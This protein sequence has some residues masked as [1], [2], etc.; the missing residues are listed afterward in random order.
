MEHLV[1]YVCTQMQFQSVEC[2][3][4]L[5][6]FIT[7]KKIYNNIIFMF[8]F[9]IVFCVFCVVFVSFVYIFSF[10][11]VSFLFLHKFTG[12]CHRVETQLQSINVYHNKSK[13]IL[14]L[15][16]FIGSSHSVGAR[17]VCCL[18]L[19]CECTSPPQ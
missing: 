16:N 12:H 15:C 6:I 2:Y 10:C 17:L 7:F 5:V 9:C 8:V 14:I 18:A 19:I 11:A 4:Y 3:I 13:P 1:I